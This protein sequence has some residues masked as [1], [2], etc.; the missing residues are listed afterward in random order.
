MLIKQFTA[1]NVSA[2]EGDLR[3]L[4]VTELSDILRTVRLPLE[5]AVSIHKTLFSLHFNK[6]PQSNGCT[7]F[8]N[9]ITLFPDR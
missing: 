3:Q 5:S 7:I 9:L 6:Q 8:L 2:P 4:D 1:V